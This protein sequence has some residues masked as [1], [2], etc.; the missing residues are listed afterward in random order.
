MLET[1]R[2]NASGWFSKILLGGIA[3][4]FALYF[5]FT[6]G[7]GG[8][9]QGGTA[10]IAKVNGKNIPSGLFNQT[11]S[12]QMSVYQQFGAANSGP[13]LQE[14]IQ[15]QV[16]QKLIQK[17]LLAQ[18][19]SKLGLYITNVELAD[20]IRNN[21]SFQKDGRFDENFY[22]K[23][24]KP[25]FERQNGE[26]FE[27]A[28]REDLLVERFQQ[29]L[30]SGAVI[31]K[32]QAKD[33]EKI[34]QTQLKWLQ[35]SVPVGAEGQGLNPEAAKKLAE[36]WIQARQNK[37]STGALLKEHQLKAEEIGPKPIAA[38]L[39]TLGPDGMEI[40][41]CLLD[42]G[43][44]SVCPQTFTG[45]DQILAVEL[46]SQEAKAPEGTPPDMTQQLARAKEGQLMTGV[47]DILT[48]QAKIETFLSK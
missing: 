39:P 29:A 32:A 44:G 13:E 8:P 21:P 9:P 10:P 25:F 31:S 14:V 33:V 6:S 23:Q 37:A 35:L 15:S 34:R 40:V 41:S 24:F 30:N 38:I 16:L 36:D 4:I 11:V 27:Y 43:T 17:S 1:L 42:Q 5:G 28:L 45:K 2:K 7:G 22:L 26:N 12:K 3:L 47:T 20:A 48:R 46:L 19:A 18:E